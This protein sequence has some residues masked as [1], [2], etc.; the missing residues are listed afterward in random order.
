MG[1]HTYTHVQLHTHTRTATHT[2]T[3]THTC[4]ATH[5]HTH[6]QLHTHTHVQLHTHTHVQLHTHIRTATHTHTH[7]YS[8][9]HKHALHTQTCTTH[10]YRQTPNTN[11]HTYTLPH[12][13]AHTPSNKV[14]VKQ[15]WAY[16]S[17]KCPHSQCLRGNPWRSHIGWHWT[18]SH[19]RVAW[20]GTHSRRRTYKWEWETEIRQVCTYT[21]QKLTE[22]DHSPQ[23]SNH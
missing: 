6:V 8:Y 4:T 7:T 19:W 20:K 3:H 2:H 22:N 14:R 15:R 21:T 17:G 12:T 23:V 18:T 5:T 13:H 11:S 1:T 16:P 10:T 9:T